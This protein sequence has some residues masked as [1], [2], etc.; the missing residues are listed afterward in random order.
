VSRK[1]GGAHRIAATQL[2]ELA[3]RLTP[4]DRA[5]CRLLAEHQV[6]AADHIAGLLYGSA[7]TARHR[8]LALHRLRVV[9]RF[10]PL[11]PLGEGSAP[12]HYV[13]GE[14]GAIVLAA[15]LGVEVH[16]LGYRRDRA[17][18]VAHSP[19]LP[20]LLAASG[21]FA[22][23]AARRPPVRPPA[24]ATAAPPSSGAPSSCAA[25]WPPTTHGSA[26]RPRHG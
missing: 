15:E 5:L 20:R 19:T 10:R 17:V 14:A 6:L 12:Y 22:A 11:T 13:L 1:R 2:A 7:H 23:L 3:G 18:A 4:E 21:F 16:Q 24:A 8:L 26:A 9:D 25:T